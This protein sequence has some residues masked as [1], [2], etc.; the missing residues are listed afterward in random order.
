V[1]H[2]DRLLGTARKREEAATGGVETRN[3]VIGDAMAADIKE[4]CVAA[5]RLNLR[6]DCSAPC[7]VMP[8]FIS[9]AMSMM[10]KVMWAIYC[11][12]AQ[13]RRRHEHLLQL[14]RANPSSRR[15]QDNRTAGMPWRLGVMI[16]DVAT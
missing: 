1:L 8:A 6:G 16:K 15:D 10:G 13:L 3:D 11:F 9:G 12:G 4:A 7:W 14:P 2:R 5:R